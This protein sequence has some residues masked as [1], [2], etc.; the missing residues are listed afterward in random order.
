MEPRQEEAPGPAQQQRHEAT[1][2]RK[3]LELIRSGAKTVEGRIASGMWLRVQAGDTITFTCNTALSQPVEPAQQ[4]ECVE[5]VA[6]EVLV[7]NRYDSF[8]AMLHG[9]GVDACL[10]GITNLDEAVAVYRSIPTYADREP[11]GV[12]GIRIRT[13]DA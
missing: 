7:V 8:A 5:P 4:E 12:L 13:V 3:Y 10:P 2:M 11:Q 9:E 1:L 6:V